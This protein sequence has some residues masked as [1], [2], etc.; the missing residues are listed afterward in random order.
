MSLSASRIR[1]LS[2]RTRFAEQAAFP[3]LHAPR[4]AFPYNVKSPIPSQFR[5]DAMQKAFARAGMA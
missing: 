1:S 5:G 3:G 4:L 2:S